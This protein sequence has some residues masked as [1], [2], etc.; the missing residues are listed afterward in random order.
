MTGLKAVSEGKVA[1][2]VLAGGQASR[3]GSP[4]PKG[5]IRLGTGFNSTTDSLLFVQ[6]AQIAR[7]QQMARERFPGTEPMITWLVMTSNT[8]DAKVRTHLDA[9]L[10]ETGLNWDQVSYIFFCLFSFL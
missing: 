5:T 8:T 9:V 4:D 6:A 7:Y 10:N 2:L 1:A 3:L